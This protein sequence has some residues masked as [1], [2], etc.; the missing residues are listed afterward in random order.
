LVGRIPGGAYGVLVATSLARRLLVRLAVFRD[1]R[2]LRPAR[3]RSASA[4]R[5]AVWASF[6][7]PAARTFLM[8]VR[9]RLRRARF[10]SFAARDFRMAFLADLRRGTD[11]LAFGAHGPAGRPAG[12]R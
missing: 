6:A 7:V 1:T 11:Y 10:R 4:S 5:N 2:F 3:S 9:S 12:K 8:A